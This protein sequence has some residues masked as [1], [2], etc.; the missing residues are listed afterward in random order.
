MTEKSELRVLEINDNEFVVQF[1]GGL[2]GW[3]TFSD[4]FKTR[5]EAESFLQEQLNNADYGA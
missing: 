1:S 4:V 5:N 3:T 2:S